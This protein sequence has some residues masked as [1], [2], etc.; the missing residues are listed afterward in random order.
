MLNS[1]ETS[2]LETL[3]WKLVN[4]QKLVEPLR[5]GYCCFCAVEKTV[6]M[7]AYVLD[8]RRI[9]KIYVCEAHEAILKKFPKA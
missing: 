9:F 7:T 2:T 8:A 1:E 6:T 3:R 5:R 4:C